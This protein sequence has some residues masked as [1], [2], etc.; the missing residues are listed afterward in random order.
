[1]FK[2][3]LVVAFVLCW[4][5][6]AIDPVHRGIWLLENILVVSVF[7][8]VLWLDKKYIFS[9]GAFLSQ[10]NPKTR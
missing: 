3:I 4:I 7:P 8:V 5:V 9:N 2:K 1:M 10:T 6:L